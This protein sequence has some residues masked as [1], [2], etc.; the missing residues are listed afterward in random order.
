MYEE[1]FCKSNNS[2]E[3]NYNDKNN[4]NNNNNLTTTVD[5]NIDTYNNTKLPYS[6][7]KD[8]IEKDSDS[9]KKINK[10]DSN[11]ENIETDKIINNNNNN[12]LSQNNITNINNKNNN[13]SIDN[14]NNNN[15]NKALENEN[16]QLKDIKATQKQ[17]NH[18]SSSYNNNYYL[19]D[20][21]VETQD[22]L[23][24]YPYLM[25]EL[26][27]L[28]P[29]NYKMAILNKKFAFNF[30][31][32]L[33]ERNTELFN[34]V[35]SLLEKNKANELDFE[36]LFNS[37]EELL[38]PHK[39]LYDEMLI[40]MDYKK[41]KYLRTYT[42]GTKRNI[43]SSSAVINNMKKLYS[44]NSF[45]NE[46]TN[47]NVSITH[48]RNNLSVKD[49]INDEYSNITGHLYN[50]K[51]RKLSLDKTDL[52]SNNTSLMFSKNNKKSNRLNADIVSVSKECEDIDINNNNNNNNS[53]NNLAH[54][55]NSNINNINNNNSNN[56]KE[57]KSQP[58]PEYRFLNSLKHMIPTDNYLN[59]T[60]LIYMYIKGVFSFN[61]FCQI[62]NLVI[63][64]RYDI[65]NIV[66]QIASSKIISRKNYSNLIKP[67]SE[68]DFSS[69]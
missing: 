20:I 39:D 50:N 42:N 56:T 33:K 44:L 9:L 29:K 62:I 67:L 63:P 59:L 28:L 6:K 51:R 1:L 36:G 53:N 61:D 57:Y 24:D 26:N 43:T 27:R 34:K 22:F 69:K 45:N 54:N 4:D 35:L 17:Q 46:N 40:L 14:N 48:D 38:K 65:I 10:K 64:N 21:L 2:K 32:K 7:D 68:I 66:K 25:I 16:S 15:N 19:E 23:I 13:I 30:L 12:S 8:S 49:N 41:Y 47:N 60:K 52:I 58:D 31:I 55:N 3:V 5:I 37:L 18:N 11:K